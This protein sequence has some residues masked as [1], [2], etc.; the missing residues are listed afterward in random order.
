MAHRHFPFVVLE[1]EAENL[2]RAGSFY[3]A[4]FGWS[5]SASDAHA[6]AVEAE[7]DGDHDPVVRVHARP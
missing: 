5:F 7:L 4:I 3:S 1:I 6:R 2:Q